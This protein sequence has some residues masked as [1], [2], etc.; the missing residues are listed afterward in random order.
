[1]SS[2]CQEKVSGMHCKFVSLIVKVRMLLGGVELGPG[3]NLF[4]SLDSFMILYSVI[5][6]DDVDPRLR[7]N[8]K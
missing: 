6:C 1:M 7:Q 2:L 5:N 8:D 3:I 4:S